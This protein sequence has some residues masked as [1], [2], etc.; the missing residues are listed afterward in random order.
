MRYCN[1][2]PVIKKIYCWNN[3]SF[4]PG[5]NDNYA[6]VQVLPVGS[7]VE[8][9]NKNVSLSHWCLDGDIEVIYDI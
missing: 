7:N 3:G 1:I 5:V 4:L 8:Q 6:G 9:M 2:K